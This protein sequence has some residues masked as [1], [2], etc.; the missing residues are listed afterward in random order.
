MSIVIIVYKLE[1]FRLQINVKKERKK[2]NSKY[3]H[4]HHRTCNI[5]IMFTHLIPPKPIW[6][7]KHLICCIIRTGQTCN[8]GPSNICS[9]TP[10]MELRLTI[11][12]KNLVLDP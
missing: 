6:I 5:P 10:W 4:K 11:F 7:R 12:V 2:V 3:Y 1:H 8:Q 9:G